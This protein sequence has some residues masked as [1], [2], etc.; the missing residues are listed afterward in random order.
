[1]P[2][3]QHLSDGGQL[4][5]GTLTIRHRTVL[6]VS[7]TALRRVER[8]PVGWVVSGALLGPEG[9]AGRSVSF[10]RRPQ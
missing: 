3:R 10:E 9:T 2:L 1:V 4:M 5:G 6:R 8:G 7:G